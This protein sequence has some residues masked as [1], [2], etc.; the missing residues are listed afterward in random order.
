MA[1]LIPMVLRHITTRIVS[2]PCRS[3]ILAR[4]ILAL[5]VFDMTELK[6]RLGLKTYA[7]LNLY[8]W[9]MHPIIIFIPVAMRNKFMNE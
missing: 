8:I 4:W 7:W 9:D 6:L 5:K 2:E 1:K 3:V